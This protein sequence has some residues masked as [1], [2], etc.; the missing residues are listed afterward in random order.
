MNN[1]HAEGNES[2][3][4]NIELVDIE[5]IVPSNSGNSLFLCIAR[6]LIYKSWK[7]PSF[8][9]QLSLH[10]ISKLDLKCDI[11]LQIA[12]RKLLCE[13]WL[14]NCVVFSRNSNTVILNEEYS[15]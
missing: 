8:S 1:T 12:L 14:T 3:V 10:G 15:K 13:Y 2:A 5:D 9:D 4:N 6:A 7:N 11:N